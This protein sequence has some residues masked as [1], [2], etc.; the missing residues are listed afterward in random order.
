MVPIDVV[1]HRTVARDRSSAHF[2]ILIRCIDEIRLEEN[3]D[4]ADE[5]RN[6]ECAPNVTRSQVVRGSRDGWVINKRYFASELPKYDE[7]G[8]V[9]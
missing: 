1:C 8:D 9:G 5:H 2:E 6:Q 3:P 7:I 4:K